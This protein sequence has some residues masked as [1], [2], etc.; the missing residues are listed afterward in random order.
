MHSIFIT[1]IS[2]FFIIINRS[3]AVSFSSNDLIGVAPQ[4]EVYYKEL[5]SSGGGGGS[6][7]CRDG[8]KSFTKAQLN[9]DFCD[10]FDGTDEPGRI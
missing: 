6:V 3:V 7:K 4:D 10:C 8:S 5:W 1:S 9:D 2:L